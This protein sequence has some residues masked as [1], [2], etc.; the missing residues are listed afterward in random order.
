M[1]PSL[2]QGPP[3]LTS[4]MSPCQC[5][6]SGPHP[7]HG[8]HF[9]RGV[10]VTTPASSPAPVPVQLS[11]RD[12]APMASLLVEAQDEVELLSGDTACIAAAP[13][14]SSC[15]FRPAGATGSLGRERKDPSTWW[16][17][18][19]CV[20]AGAGP[21]ALDTV[22]RTSLGIPHAACIDEN[23]DMVKFLVENRAD[24]NRQD[25]EGW[26]PLHAAASCGY[27]NIAEYFLSHG[28]SVSIVNS[29][30]EVPSDLAEEPAMKDLLLEQVKKQGVDLEQAR[31]EEEQQ[32]LQDSRQWLNSGKIED[33]RQAR[34][35]ATAL[36]VAAAK[37]YS[38]VLRLLIQAGYDLDV[39]DHD[40]WTPL[41]AAAHWGVKEACSILAEA[42]CNM[43]VRNKL[44]LLSPK[45]QRPAFCFR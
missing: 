7:P 12:A 26:T 31:K 8:G 11:L 2:T 34:S 18:Q 19:L 4:A 15:H 23:F 14:A 29:E 24:V 20:G 43:D 10:P 21:V 25:N 45:L 28:A 41:H 36:H 22:F 39:Q 40:G 44:G 5:L 6:A 16:S 1:S 35:G 32:M 30:G 17:V 38:E 33:T 13:S 42:L 27:L 3:A 37:G 9:L